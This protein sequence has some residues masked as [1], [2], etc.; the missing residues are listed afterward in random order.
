MSK[1]A[2]IFPGQGAQYTG[3]GRDFYEQTETGRKVF[4]QASELLG[5]SM[6]ELVFEPNDRLDITEYTQAAMVTT[7]IAMMKVFTERTGIRPDVAAGL[8]LGE[9]CALAAAGVMSDADAI[10]TVRQRGILMQQA[11]PVGIGSMAAVLGMEASA[12]EEVLASMD[13]VQIANYNC[14]GQI[15]I[16]G[17]ADAVEA[18]SEALKEAG[19]K[20]CI[21]LKVSGPFH[22]ALLK[23]AGEQLAEELK[24]VK[25]STPWIPYVSNVTADYVTDASQ[26]AELLKQQVSSPV[27]FT[28][29]IERMI[30][31]GVD[32]FIEIGPGKTL[33]SFV[34]KIDGNVKVYNIEKPEDLDRVMEELAC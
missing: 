24:S 11:V 8:S 19:A 28:Q 6:P 7:S 4:D 25:L 3:M 34:R 9:Y 21:P 32:T 10:T 1:I 30:A 18:A 27:Q 13:D 14:P 12:I 31:D 33:S 16:T 26:V 22:S 5:F 15:V 17:E 2:F 20:R 23:N 29:S